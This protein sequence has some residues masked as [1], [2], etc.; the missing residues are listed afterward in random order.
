M[1]SLPEASG[2]VFLWDR[3]ALLVAWGLLEKDA[4][5]RDLLWAG[6]LRAA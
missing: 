1:R 3:A 4:A 5:R 6:H 2:A